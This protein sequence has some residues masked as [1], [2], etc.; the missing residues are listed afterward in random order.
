[1]SVT[2]Y[3]F[4]NR[5]VSAST[6]SADAAPPPPFR[7]RDRT[8]RSNYRIVNQGRCPGGQGSGDA[9]SPER[10]TYPGARNINHSSAVVLLD[11]L[12][13]TFR[14]WYSAGQVFFRVNRLRVTVP[15]SPTIPGRLI[16]VTREIAIRRRRLGFTQNGLFGDL[17][18]VH[19]RPMTTPVSVCVYIHRAPSPPPL[20]RYRTGTKW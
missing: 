15:T 17:L 13:R 8:E 16:T 20:S 7:D 5:V 14:R 9:R 4:E 2:G 6:F 12:V 3:R 18:S 10:F 1:M 11:P 19:A